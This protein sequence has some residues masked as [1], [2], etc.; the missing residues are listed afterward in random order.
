ML[1]LFAGRLVQ[2]EGFDSRAYRTDSAQNHPLISI[3]LPAIRGDITTS[4]GALL[5]T[6]VQTETVFADPK[7][8]PVGSRSEVAGALAGPL[9]M[10]AAAILHGLNH[11][12][13]PEYQVLG[14]NV[15]FG[16]GRQIAALKLTGIDMRATYTTSYPNGDLAGP[17]TGFTHAN[18]ADGT[19][20]GVLGL[21][22][23]YNSILSG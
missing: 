9:R 22:Q 13:S 3:A 4:D 16:V 18:P 23:E 17:V 8:I 7:L 11:P 20:S 1:T 19:L 10:P 5:T 2:L 14:R 12:S 21:E 15:S 6:T